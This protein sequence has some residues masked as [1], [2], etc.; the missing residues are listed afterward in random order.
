MPMVGILGIFIMDLDLGWL[1][2]AGDRGL[3]DLTDLNLL[4]KLVY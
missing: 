4:L 1:I 2:G 3:T